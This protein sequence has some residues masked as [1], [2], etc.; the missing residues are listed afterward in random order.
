M[1]GRL[2]KSKQTAITLYIVK[3]NAKTLDFRLKRDLHQ[4]WDRLDFDKMSDDGKRRLN[5]EL[6][7]HKEYKQGFGECVHFCVKSKY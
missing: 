1:L 7:T 2:R 4:L 3:Y 6:I 5:Q